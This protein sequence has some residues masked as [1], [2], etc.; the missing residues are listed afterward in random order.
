MWTGCCQ[1]GRLLWL[2]MHGV[3]FTPNHTESLPFM[4]IFCA[5][6][7]PEVTSATVHT[8]VSSLPQ[9]FLVMIC[10]WD[11][12]YNKPDV[13]CCAC[14]NLSPFHSW[15]GLHMAELKTCQH[16]HSICLNAFIQ[17]LQILSK[18]ATKHT[19]TMCKWIHAT[20]EWQCNWKAGEEHSV[21]YL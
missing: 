20:I 4:S 18:W 14:F 5:W 7:L 9:S 21:E 2:H 12:A 16:G 8:S 17:S 15:L 11:V 3:S 10:S 19:H 13:S 1:L 6:S